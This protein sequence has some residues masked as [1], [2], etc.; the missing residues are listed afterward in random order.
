MRAPK[1]EHRI[2]GTQHY[3]RRTFEF[4]SEEIFWRREMQWCDEKPFAGS[5]VPVPEYDGSPEV[6]CGNCD[7]VAFQIRY[8]GYSCLARC[9]KCGVEEEV[10]GG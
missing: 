5:L 10:Y 2:V 4:D 6:I 3:D 8:G 9:V 7:G 1:A